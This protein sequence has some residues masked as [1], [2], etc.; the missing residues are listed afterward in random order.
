[1][2][3]GLWLSNSWIATIIWDDNWAHQSPFP[4]WDLSSRCS[5]LSRALNRE[6]AD[7][8]AGFCSGG[9]SSG[10]LANRLQCPYYL[11]IEYFRSCCL[12]HS[13]LSK[14]IK[15]S[16]Q[17][18]FS[19]PDCTYQGSLQSPVWAPTIPVPRDSMSKR[20][21]KNWLRLPRWYV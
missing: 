11:Y 16:W 13:H 3:F 1:M 18:P 19:L 9:S 12:Q 2:I 14:P 20:D 15:M 7:E 5:N 17:C 6:H 8:S 4:S 21:L 10:S